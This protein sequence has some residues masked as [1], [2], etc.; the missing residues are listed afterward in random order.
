[1]L[2]D[3]VCK[4][5]KKAEND[6]EIAK[7]I[8]GEGFYGEST[9]HSQQA[10]EKALKAL[11]VALDVQPPKSHNIHFLLK[12]LEENGVDTTIPRR[13]RAEKLTIYAVEARYPDF[14]EEPSA[15]EAQEALSIA[16]RVVEWVRE[17]LG[18]MGVEC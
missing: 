4:W 16:G 3:I 5:I 17:K 9:F 15:S 11:L 1:M 7:I 10:A 8:I 2:E 14:G 13:M 18:E 6:L 12:L